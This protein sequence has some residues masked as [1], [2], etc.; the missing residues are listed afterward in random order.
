MNTKIKWDSR[1]INAEAT[2]GQTCPAGL[3][4]AVARIQERQAVCSQINKTEL[5]LQGL[6]DKL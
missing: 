6:F 4:Q 1:G 2:G 3:G 5:S